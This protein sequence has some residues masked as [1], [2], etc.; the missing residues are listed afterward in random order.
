MNGVTEIRLKDVRCFGGNQSARTSRITL[1]VGENSVGKSTF[2]GCYR[3]L[4]N[5]INLQGLHD[6]NH[7]HHPPFHMETHDTITRSG[8]SDFKIGGSFEG[9]CYTGAEF[10]FTSD[11]RGYPVEK[12]A[13]FDFP[14]KD[15]SPRS[16]NISHIKEPREI[17]RFKSDGLLF[18]LDRWSVSYRH[19]T[20]WLSQLVRQG[21]LPFEGRAEIYKKQGANK[22]NKDI[23]R[24]NDFCNFF[25]S[26]FPMP[27]DPS[28]QVR[29]LDPEVPPREPYYAS[30]PPYMRDDEQFLS[31]LEEMGRRLKLWKKVSIRHIQGGVEILVET[32]AGV[33]NIVHIGYGIHSLLPLLN[34]MHDPSPNTIFLLQQ[35][36]VYIHPS[37]QAELAQIM[38]ESESGF[39]VETHSEYI[40]D[41][42]RI[43]VI[44]GKM[45][46]E[47]ISIIYFEPN[48]SRTRT[49]LHNIEMDSA[50]NLMDVPDNYRSFFLD[51]TMRL[52][53]IED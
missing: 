18:D 21:H 16:L 34:V 53:G 3:T 23:I 28:F 1:L 44:E 7:F 6:D 32:K 40:L 9:H 35:P 24:F 39:V 41:R 19:I 52:L 47:D 36:E 8:A 13:R 29:I 4:I 49:T 33:H 11:S 5:L 31:Y 20:S 45:K 22:T 27:G 50:G 15:G 17:L 30:L 42:F 51:E 37:V 38:S 12:S 2:L 46:P 43:N 25:R 48:K 10:V 14:G 26:S